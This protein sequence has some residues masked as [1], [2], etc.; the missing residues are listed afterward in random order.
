VRTGE[1][2]GSIVVDSVYTE[3]ELQYY[4]DFLRKMAMKKYDMPKSEMQHLLEGHNIKSYSTLKW[5]MRLIGFDYYY[6]RILFRY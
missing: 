5:L 2:Q 1:P 3:T 6:E 4:I